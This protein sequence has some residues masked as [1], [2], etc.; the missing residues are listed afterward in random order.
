MGRLL[1]ECVI[2]NQWEP[3]AVNNEL[4]SVFWINVQRN[5]LYIQ[6]KIYVYS[7]T[8]L[9]VVLIKRFTFFLITIFFTFSNGS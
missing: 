9:L 8:H 2:G 5:P 4:Q 7:Y 6:L 3:W 1:G